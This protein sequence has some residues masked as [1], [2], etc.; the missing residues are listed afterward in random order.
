MLTFNESHICQKLA[1]LP[2]WARVVFAST[3]ATRL[4]RAYQA[5]CADT[6]SGDSPQLSSILEFIWHNIS[7]IDLDIPRINQ[8]IEVATKL[9]PS[10]DDA[11]SEFFS[12]A[13]D[14]VASVLYALR[15]M[16]T[17]ECQEAAW[18][19]RRSYEAV[20]DYVVSSMKIDL[21]KKDSEVE[22]LGHPLVQLE[23]SRQLRDLD[24]L[25]SEI[26]MP[27]DSVIKDFRCRAQIEYAIPRE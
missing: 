3:V 12:P 17:G 9:L 4:F 11:W 20:D 2:R 24:K 25:Q 1:S 10:E 7:R 14:A 8:S 26:D 6:S 15:T 27:I 21:Q 16:V 19:A 5:Y 23:L 18:A 13:E 22:V